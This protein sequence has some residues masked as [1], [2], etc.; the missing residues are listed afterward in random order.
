VLEQDDQSS[1]VVTR[2]LSTSFDS[3]AATMRLA[4]LTASQEEIDELSRTFKMVRPGIDEINRA[5]PPA[6]LFSLKP[7]PSAA[8]HKRSSRRGGFLL[9]GIIVLVLI[10]LAAAF[11]L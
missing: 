9:L 10:G 7:P 1:P 11:L 3:A 5:A 6:T 4:A 2:G 8:K